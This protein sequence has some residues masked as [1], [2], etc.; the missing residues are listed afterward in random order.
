[1]HR[2]LLAAFVATLAA[3]AGSVHAHN[4]GVSSARIVVEGRTVEVE[5]NARFR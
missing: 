3:A 1:L 5:I 4:A 2:F